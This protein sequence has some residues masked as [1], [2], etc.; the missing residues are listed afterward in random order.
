MKTALKNIYTFND[1]MLKEECE[2]KD[3]HAAL[4]VLHQLEA[5]ISVYLCKLRNARMELTNDCTIYT[6]LPSIIIGPLF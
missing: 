2:A 1:G 4:R 5:A 3:Y 6:F